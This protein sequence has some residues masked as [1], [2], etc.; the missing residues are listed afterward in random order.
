MFLK[1]R[2]YRK[3]CESLS[4]STIRTCFTL[5]SYVASWTVT[6]VRCAT[7]AAIQTWWSTLCYTK[8]KTMKTRRLLWGYY[9]VDPGPWNNMVLFFITR[10][11]ILN[12]VMNT[13][14][15]YIGWNLTAPLHLAINADHRTVWLVNLGKIT[16]RNVTFSRNT[17]NT[18]I[19]LCIHA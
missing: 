5:V 9:N 17:A 6:N 3:M 13:V 1:W 15:L 2:P 16:C 4:K 18:L 14:L 7:Y 19:K 8:I 10:D 12:Y 11:V